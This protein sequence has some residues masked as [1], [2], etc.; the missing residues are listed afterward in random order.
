MLARLTQLVNKFEG[1]TDTQQEL[2]VMIV[3]LPKPDGGQRP[4]GLLPSIARLWGRIQVPV[5]KA[6]EISHRLPC[7]VRA[8]LDC[9]MA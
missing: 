6:W 4:I 1:T 3:Y 8:G 5:A 7:F 2:G 9:E